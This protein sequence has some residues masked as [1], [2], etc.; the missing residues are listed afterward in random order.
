[1]VA[2]GRSPLDA[3]VARV[4]AASGAPVGG[5]FLAA[6]GHLLTA[7]HV[8]NLAHGRDR[9]A[10]DRPTGPV[11]VDFPLVD[12]GVLVPAELVRWVPPRTDNPH[13]VAEDVVALR[14]DGPVPDGAA[15]VAL[16]DRSD[17]FDRRVV[18]LGFPALLDSG[19]WSIGRLRG[20]LA[21]G[22]IQIDMDPASQFAI[23]G[24]FSGAPV[25]DVDRSAAVGMVVAAWRGPQ[26]R[27][28]YMIPTAM[29]Q[30]AWPALRAMA[31]PPSPFPGL[32][33]YAEEDAAA[34]FG[35]DELTGR[36]VA[37]T[38]SAPVVTVVGPSGVGKSSLLRAGVLP[39]VRRHAGTLVLTARPSE[40]RTPLRSLALALDRATDPDV[41]PVARLDR[42]TALAQ[43]LRQG[44]V[45]EIV[46]AVLDRRRLERMLLVV[47]QWE[48][49]FAPPGG[50]ADD[51][52]RVLGAALEPGAR[53]AV[54][55]GL[56]VDFLGQALRRPL[57]APLV[58]DQWLVTVG[59][60]SRAELREVVTRP[61]ERTRSVSYEEG[62][63]D[64]LLTDVG[65]APGQLPLVQFVLAELWDRQADG[66]LSH[67][68]YRELGG[69][70]R[71]LAGHAEG[72][73]TGL[74]QADRVAAERL[75][76]QL[77][78]P[79]PDHA[80][81]TGRLAPRTDLDDRQW[82]IAGRLAT[83]RLVVVREVER[84]EPAAAPTLGA[85]LAHESLLAHWDRLREL[86][87]RERQ[88][89][90]WQ[91]G[92]R[93]RLDQ[94][95]T[96][97]HARNRLLSGADLRDARR[98]ERSHLADLS[99][100]ERAYL[101][102]S[103]ERRRVVRLRAVA[104]VVVLALVAG[105]LWTAQRRNLSDTAASRL[106]GMA[107]D[108]A[109]AGDGYAGTLL[110]LRAYRTARNAYAQRAVRQRYAETMPVDRLLPADG[111]AV[112][113]V[114]NGRAVARGVV[115]SVVSADG[116]ALVTVTGDRKPALWR[117]DGAA[118]TPVRLDSDPVSFSGRATIGA[119]GH[120]A[121][122]LQ[123]VFP[124]VLPGARHSA[125][126]PAN[127][128]ATTSCLAAYDLTTR[129]IAVTQPIA[130]GSTVDALSIDATEQAVA[131]VVHGSG[132]WSVQ[133]WD[134]P[135]GRPRATVALPA[136]AVEIPGFW[137]APGARRGAVLT[138]LPQGP[139]DPITSYSLSTVD[140]SSGAVTP[141]VTGL[142]E[143]GAAVSPDGARIAAAVP[144]AGSPATVELR[145]WDLPSGAEVGRLG[146]VAPQEGFGHLALDGTGSRL[147][148][149]W[150]PLDAA[151]P[152]ALPAD[153]RSIP[154][155]LAS[156]GKAY[157]EA[158][159]VHVSVWT[160]GG[161]RLDRT[162]LR[163][164]PSW[165]LA[166]PLGAGEDAPIALLG[167]GQVGLVLPSG[168]GGPQRR[169]DR[170]LPDPTS[171]DPRAA[172]RHLCGILADRSE[173]ADLRNKIPKGAYAG[174]ICP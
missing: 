29:L 77:V 28:G 134:L 101:K 84:T 40:A 121:A 155:P 63:V 54:L 168:A 20:R 125:C 72:V 53:F 86:A 69:V 48:E 95:R 167:P 157:R 37:M 94:W 124:P 52:G 62:L 119:G 30:E 49:A 102:A 97:Q 45:R 160:V 57:T 92:L 122:F 141:L 5:A 127:R 76:A 118:V 70:Q 23:Q 100:A 67:H 123:Q 148:I 166:R 116:H 159:T 50:N 109:G 98:W 78:R 25:W 171:L 22:W 10:T 47:D 55:T 6:P 73:W 88:F 2:T 51:L 61:V 129:R 13:G 139:G 164:D 74:G 111:L 65:H 1:M 71:A 117:V 107:D 142:H 147:F 4:W 79:T 133:S 131:A 144:V 130:D 3:A 12:P 26:V 105:L 99:A 137:L 81:F 104:V 163:F 156:I 33:A 132:G 14:L 11:S 31:R 46:G 87:R 153:I 110:A 15:P 140:L 21:T 24:G 165:L 41:E 56:R 59:E 90:L 44:E 150:L 151:P 154:G 82:E 114:V 39:Q 75:L 7:A 145:V 80:T 19:V 174:P 60:L 172:V 32:R 91:D 16:V 93:A 126:S 149:S 36:V 173:S 66:R 83:A 9:A 108:Y 96:H 143:H 138:R 58:Q 17:L 135:S 113:E 27:T 34:F 85:E 169:L 18:V 161:D 146:G 152:G 120:Y 89:R 38:R 103:R 136:A 64:R 170:P 158:T 162:G 106:A 8:V 112:G 35:R 42:V 68:A 115:D 43:R 128:Y